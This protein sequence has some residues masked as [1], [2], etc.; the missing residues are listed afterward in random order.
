MFGSL[1]KTISKTFSRATEII[2][3]SGPTPAKQFRNA[4]VDG[5]EDKAIVIYTTI[6]KEGS[7]CLYEELHPSMPFPSKKP[8]ISDTPLSLASKYALEKLVILL[9]EHGGDPGALNFN[10]ETCIHAVCR[11]Q[12][13]P[14]IRARII[15]HFMNW[16]NGYELGFISEKVSVNKVD[17]NGNTAIHNAA[18]AGLVNCVEMLVNIGA[19]I[20]IVNKGNNTCCELA[21]SNGHKNLAMMLE[22]A[23]VFQA[24]DCDL[25]QFDVFSIGNVGDR[26]AKLYLDTHSITMEGIHSFVE[27]AVER[28]SDYLGSMN[29]RR[30]RSRAEALLNG[31]AWEVDRLCKDLI[32]NGTKVLSNAKM[33]STTCVACPTT[34]KSLA[35]NTA[36]AQK[37]SQDAEFTNVNEINIDIADGEMFGKQTEVKVLST[38]SP[39][40]VVPDPILCTICCEEM[41]PEHDISFYLRNHVEKQGRHCLSCLSGHSYCLDCWSS[42]LK[43]QISENGLGYMS[44]P[45]YKCGEIL[46]LF[47][48]PMLLKSQVLVNRLRNQRALHVADCAGFK[49]CPV[50]GCGLRVHIPKQIDDSLEGQT[51]SPSLLRSPRSEAPVATGTNQITHVAM[52]DNN[53]LFCVSCFQTAHSPCTCIQFP[54]WLQLVREE[55]KSI[56]ADPNASLGDDLANALWV[57]ANTKRCPRCGTAIEKDEGCNHMTCRKCRKEFCWI[58]LQDWSLHSQNTGGYFQCNRFQD[59]T[60]RI[61]S[62]EREAADSLDERGNAHADA[63][64]MRQRSNKMARF[65]HHFTRF[66]AHG[67]SFQMESRMSKDTYK[68]IDDG[69]KAS[70]NGQLKWLPGEMV[71]HPMAAS[72]SISPPCNS[73]PS[74]I[75]DTV[76]KETAMAP[77][78]APLTSGIHQESRDHAQSHLG[79]LFTVDT[80]DILSRHYIKSSAYLQFLSDGFHE[81]LKCR[82]VKKHAHNTLPN[83]ME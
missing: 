21:D 62:S 34:G 13:K 61:S 57:A 59:A 46:E 35:T 29:A 63:L 70:L 2:T 5:D 40:V 8:N 66:Q 72:T 28:I 27:E 6:S 17:I 51:P 81:L 53:H 45:G 10:Q 25:S 16:N 55:M 18:S 38:V 15:E 23:L 33:D 43:V 77:L 68:R 42:H 24:D 37:E 76:L 50:E 71:P 60:G 82:Q 49:T 20:S 4:I 19:I 26:S 79:N 83:T 64:R 54:H 12:D 67:Q 80:S 75:R 65:I 73:N 1:R 47:W 32:D 52:C 14:I 11:L 30:Y 78:K 7:K 22:L 41:L 36:N 39:V 44:C 3:G 69:L 9:L 56:G 58:C 31:Y 48:A 74:S